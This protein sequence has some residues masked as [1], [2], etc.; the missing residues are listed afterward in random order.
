MVVIGGPDDIFLINQSMAWISCPGMTNKAQAGIINIR[1]VLAGNNQFF[2]GCF[3]RI[4]ISSFGIQ[5]GS[6][7]LPLVI[8]RVINVVVT[9]AGVVVMLTNWPQYNDLDV[10]R[11]EERAGAAPLMIDC[12]RIYRN[13]TLKKFTYRAF[14]MVT[15]PTGGIAHDSRRD[16]LYQDRRGRTPVLERTSV[17][18]PALT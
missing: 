1:I 13:A 8:I 4:I 6:Q 15:A 2:R 16:I 3:Q 11:L 18:H 7:F 14:G 5:G 9:G 17:Q 10:A 12:W